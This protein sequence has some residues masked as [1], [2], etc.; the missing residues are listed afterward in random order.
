MNSLKASLLLS[1]LFASVA[2]AAAPPA[3]QPTI[4]DAEKQAGWK[5]LFDGATKTGWRGLGRDGFPDDRWRIENGCLHCPGGP[6]TRWA[7]SP[8]RTT[9]TKCGSAASRSGS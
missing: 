5:L 1:V 7:T 8:S 9:T 4:T 6:A 3:T 2:V